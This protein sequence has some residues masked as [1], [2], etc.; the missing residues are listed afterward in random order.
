MEEQ[1]RRLKKRKKKRRRQPPL[2]KDIS[3]HRKNANRAAEKLRNGENLTD[4][5]VVSLFKTDFIQGG[6]LQIIV[7]ELYRLANP[8]I[9]NNYKWVD[10]PE[11]V[12]DCLR[13]WCQDVEVEM[14]A[15]FRRHPEQLYSLT[16]RRFEELIA[17]IFSNNGFSVELTPKTRDGGVDIIAVHK[18]AL[19][20]NAVHLVECKRYAP[21][22]S[23]GIGV[24]Q[25]LLGAVTQRRANKGVIVTTS[26]FTKDAMEVAKCTENILSLKDYGDILSWLRSLRS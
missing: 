8:N 3:S 17:A 12:S 1:E 11:V 5:E 24:V 21:E 6:D 7:D 19:T 2:P 13:V 23:V 18:S 10:S 25:R 15:Y 9:L 26:F 22:N 14:L 20:G 4:L 16:P